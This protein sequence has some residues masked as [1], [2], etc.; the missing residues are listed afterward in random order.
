MKLT[1]ILLIVF[2]LQLS[3]NVCAQKITLSKTDAGLEDILL[4]INKQTGYSY[5]VN[6]AILSKSQKITLNVKNAGLE[7][8]LD[9]CFKDQPLSYLIKDN[10]IIIKEKIKASDSPARMA[11]PIDGRKDPSIVLDNFPY[12]GGSGNINPR[13]VA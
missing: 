11:S 13:D 9:E 10:T 7:S 3:A 1:T 6:S 4:E 12:E 8:V 2:C 5:S